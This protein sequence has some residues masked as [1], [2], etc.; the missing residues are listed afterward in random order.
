MRNL[1]FNKTSLI[2][3]LVLGIFIL[4]TELVFALDLVT[5]ITNL[6]WK[7]SIFIHK[8]AHNLLGIC[9][10]TFHFVLQT[11]T[12]LLRT[13]IE[14]QATT[15]LWEFMK[16]LGNLIIT[17]FFL[18]VAVRSALENSL[19]GSQTS[20]ETIKKIMLLIVAALLINFSG[21]FV[22]F[23]VDLSN[24]I[25]A[26]LY[27]EISGLSK[28]SEGI[29]FIDLGIQENSDKVNEEG[30]RDGSATLEIGY[31][32]LFF[33]N[34][35]AA[36]VKVI[37]GVLILIGAFQFIARM[38]DIFLVFITSPLGILGYFNVISSGVGNLSKFFNWW[39][40]TFMCAILYP[41][42]YLF[43]LFILLK[44]FEAIRIDIEDVPGSS[45]GQFGIIAYYLLISVILIF[46]FYKIA[47]IKDKVC[48]AFGKESSFYD[49]KLDA[50]MKKAGRGITFIPRQ[51]GRIFKESF[52]RRLNVMNE[53]PNLIRSIKE[54]PRTADLGEKAKRTI[55]LGLEPSKQ[56]KEFAERAKE[57]RGFRKEIKETIEEK[58][59]KQR[60]SNALNEGLLKTA[61]L[62]NLVR[63]DEKREKKNRNRAFDTS[64]YMEHLKNT[65]PDKY[66]ELSDL[67]RS[68]SIK[69][70]LD[71]V[72]DDVKKWKSGDNNDGGDGDDNDGGDGRGKI[73]SNVRTDDP[74]KKRGLGDNS[75]KPK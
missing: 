63:G 69:N 25:I 22:L 57:E 41:I 36:T 34:I 42:A 67:M 44:M 19:S 64:D 47:G 35:I 43:S 38:I 61:T 66:R 13:I 60:R 68:M 6:I 10:G 14:Q 24:L 12:N 32:Y 40:G 4:S 23:F 18:Y 46:S 26:L 16:D 27:S 3:I 70:F 51:Y 29:N 53:R 37:L 49:K 8:I 5:I 1:I 30:N 7:F 33:V 52:N 59:L 28:I 21:Y 39:R 17:G 71:K 55:T 15:Q 50:L 48:E 74:N 45:L 73:D 20:S 72:D 56:D 65:N 31:I 2:S 75:D 58:N 62:G 11:T 54:S 9:L